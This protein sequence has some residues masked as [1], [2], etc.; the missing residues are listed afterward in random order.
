MG[1][2]I[3]CVA[4]KFS[5]GKWEAMPLEPRPFDMRGY[6]VFAFLAGVRNYSGVTPISEPKGFPADASKAALAWADEYGTDG[7]SHSWLW[8]SDLLD[9]DYDAEIE[10]R[11]VTRQL[12]PNMWS[13]GETCEPGEGTKTTLREFLGGWYFSEITR[14]RD[15][16]VG[17]LL[18][19][20][21]N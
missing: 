15:A 5:D 3:H 19:F 21:D 18:F 9:F 17:R 16:G 11:R 20:F 1:C 4:E 7:H 12:A 8:M 2:D 13:G 10:D 6:G 14:L